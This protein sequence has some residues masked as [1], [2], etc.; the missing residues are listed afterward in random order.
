MELLFIS[1]ESRHFIL[2]CY[3]LESTFPYLYLDL[4]CKQLC[5]PPGKGVNRR[6][7]STKG[8]LLVLFSSTDDI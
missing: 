6:K 7:E 4:A 2:S 5:F 8:E 3:T 1:R